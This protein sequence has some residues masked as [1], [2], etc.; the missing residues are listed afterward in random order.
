MALFHHKLPIREGRVVIFSVVKTI[1]NLMNVYILNNAYQTRCSRNMSL[2]V[3]CWLG[4]LHTQDWEPMTLT[5]QALS[6]VEKVEPV[7]ITSHYAWGTNEVCECKMDAKSTWIPTWYRMDHVP[8]SLGIIFINRLLKVGLTQ[9]HDTMTL[10]ML[11]T[12]D[13]FY[14]YHVWGPAWI[15]ILWNSIW[16]RARSHMISHYIWGSV[17]TQ[18]DFG[19]VL[20]R[21]LDTFF[22]ALTISWLWLFTPQGGHYWNFRN[23]VRYKIGSI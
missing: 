18:H 21:S 19:G 23:H 10:R 1:T 6:L 17:T 16:M 12:I 7:K 9:N 3:L 2:H 11:T 5:L 20:G 14:L 13:F 8:W 15:E 22:W 4:P